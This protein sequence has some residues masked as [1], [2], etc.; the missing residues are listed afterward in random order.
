MRYFIAVGQE[1]NFHKAAA[2]LQISQPSLW[3]QIQDLEDDF[4]VKLI[5]R[6]RRG[7]ALT[8]AG[9]V[10]MQE[11]VRIVQQ[12]HE[13]KGLVLRFAEGRAGTLRIA[14]N[15]IASRNGKLPLFFREYRSRHPDIELQLTMM[16]S[17]QQF[18][19]LER[20]EI[21]AGFLFNRDRGGAQLGF[22]NIARDDHV[23]AVSRQHPLAETKEIRLRDL[24]GEPLIFP[25]Q[26]H[27]SIHHAR[28]MAACVAG[29]LL[30][31]IVQRTD[32]EETLLNMV[33]T[34]MGLAL[35][36]ASC[37][38]RGYEEVVLRRIEDLSIPVSLDLAWV[39]DRITPA[40]AR[41]ITLAG[42]LAPAAE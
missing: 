32:N 35:V 16:M 34:G 20:G 28:L 22:L 41:F 8:A 17:E 31:T 13:A 11:A 12:V 10:L 25:S 40:L 15:E 19:A 7:I 9:D 30:P 21:D 6:G 1:L 23:L 26:T 37:A 27:N 2:R 14:F 4:G 18:A 3:R 33:S 38:E 36:N 42:D 29:G 24:T 39:K 5:V